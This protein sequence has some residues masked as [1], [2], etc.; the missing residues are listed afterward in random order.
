MSSGYLSDAG[1]FLIDTILG[2]FILI[3]LLRFLFQL[4]KADFYNPISQFVLKMSNR[5]IMVLR[6]IIPSFGRL[7]FATVV[8]L[9]ILESAR[10]AFTSL[11]IGHSP[12][13]SG[14]VVLSIGE[15]LKLSIY[16]L[17][18]SIFIRA[19]LSWFSMG[20]YNPVIQLLYSFT[21]PMMAP[22][23]RFLP[24][25]TGLDLSPI[26]LFFLLMLLIKLLV[27]PIL[28]IG[29]ILIY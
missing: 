20:R 4:M 19:I 5:P 14:V 11:L 21:E 12:K 25:I 27:Q 15:L 22:I 2:L 23:R 6:N 10:I 8:L 28:D 7:D 18:F 29:R 9:L 17:I 26:I 3:V 13:L 1:L 24:T 16:V